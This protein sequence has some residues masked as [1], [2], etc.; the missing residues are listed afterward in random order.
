MHLS[1]DGSSTANSIDNGNSQT[2]ELILSIKHSTHLPIIFLFRYTEWNTFPLSL[3]LKTQP[4]LSIY[5]LP[6]DEKQNMIMIPIFGI[7][8]NI[9]KAKKEKKNKINKR[10]T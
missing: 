7:S 5:R 4:N 2:M 1:Y 6:N 10:V 8:K 3:P 9:I